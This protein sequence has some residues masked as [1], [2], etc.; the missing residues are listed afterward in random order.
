MR[1]QATPLPL[2]RQMRSDLDPVHVGRPDESLWTYPRGHAVVERERREWDGS[3]T[4][5]RVRAAVVIRRLARSTR[6]SL[7]RRRCRFVR[8]IQALFPRRVHAGP[9]RGVGVGSARGRFRT[10]SGA[11]VSMA[12]EVCGFDG[13]GELHGTC[14]CTYI[15]YY[16]PC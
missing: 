1:A 8:P 2:T 15:N 6:Q 12:R 10:C 16:L 5:P 14:R 4:A 13:L 9:R 11:V 3:M 7:P